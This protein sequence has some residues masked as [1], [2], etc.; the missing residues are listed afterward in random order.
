MKSCE[1]PYYEISSVLVSL[2][3]STVELF[4]P[5]HSPQTASTSVV[6][7][8]YFMSPFCRLGH[9]KHTVQAQ[10][11]FDISHNQLI[12][13]VRVSYFLPPQPRIPLLAGCP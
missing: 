11:V 1:A 9:A 12:N 2:P 4:F 7:K 13:L 10:G 3:L 6:L 5:A 8:L